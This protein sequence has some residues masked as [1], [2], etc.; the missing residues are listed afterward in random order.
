M[1]FIYILGWIAVI[2]AV[3]WKVNSSRELSKKVAKDIK[4]ANP[5]ISKED[6]NE[7]VRGFEN[8]QRGDG[9]ISIVTGFWIIAGMLFIFYFLIPMFSSY[10]PGPGPEENC[11]GMSQTYSC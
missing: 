2:Y 7:E 6:L 1:D 5:N 11:H 10:E 3:G 9:W 8:T 4:E